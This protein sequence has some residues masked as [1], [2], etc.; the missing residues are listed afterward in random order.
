MKIYDFMYA[1]KLLAH[2]EMIP[3]ELI[4]QKITPKAIN[5]FRRDKDL[6]WHE[7]IKGKAMMVPKSI[8]YVG[9]WGGVPHA[10]ART[11]F[12]TKK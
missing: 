5:K 12:N 11:F 7:D 4:G 10:S 3:D 6:G 8:I 2:P 1:E 9:K